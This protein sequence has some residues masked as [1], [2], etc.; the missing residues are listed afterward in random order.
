MA[1][2]APG[3]FCFALNK[4]LLAILNGM[5]RM[6]AFAILTSCRYLGL[7]AGLLVAM[8]LRLPGAAL[9][10]AVSFSEVT[11]SLLL[12]VILRPYWK[13][14]VARSWR[15]Y[16]PRHLRFACKAFL[17]GALIELHARVD[18]LMLGWLLNDQITG[19][20]TFAAMA[21]GGFMQFPVVL[22]YNYNPQLSH[23]LHH[24]ERQALEK[25]IRAGRSR[26][27]RLTLLISPVAVAAYAVAVSLFFSS[28][29]EFIT[30]WIPFAILMGGLLAASGYLPF[31]EILAMSGHPGWQTAFVS[32]NVLVNI[33]LNLFFIPR[34]GMN[35]A[36]LAT[37]LALV[38]STITL[39]VFTRV[40][41]G[42]RLA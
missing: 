8:G 17:S 33:G 1:A 9:T 2:I 6:R 4:T 14:P 35:G 25:L 3:L 36:A 39:V 20:Y 42:V 23:L 22:Q 12:L 27:Y 11:L 15:I 31:H 5:H 37:A 16:F 21:Y 19:V 30:S 24:G 29:P 40:C 28:Q 18:I 41:T 32:L 34:L 38:V 10:V 26:L 7:L 13:R